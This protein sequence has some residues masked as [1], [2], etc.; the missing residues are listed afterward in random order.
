[1]GQKRPSEER[2]INV[3]NPSERLNEPQVQVII[4]SIQNVDKT[5]AEPKSQS[6]VVSANER[7]YSEVKHNELHSDIIY[8]DGKSQM[9]QANDRGGAYPETKKQAAAN[10]AHCNERLMQEGKKLIL[11][12]NQND[13]FYPEPKKQ[14]ITSAIQSSERA[15]VE[16]KKNVHSNDRHKQGPNTILTND[17]PFQEGKQRILTIDGHLVD[18]KKMF[19][20]IQVERQYHELKQAVPLP[21]YQDLSQTITS[22]D[23]FTEPKKM[24]HG[25]QT[26][27][28]DRSN[29]LDSKAVNYD[30]LNNNNNGKIV[31]NNYDNGKSDCFDS[32]ERKAAFTCNESRR[33][34]NSSIDRSPEDRFMK[35][36]GKESGFHEQPYNDSSGVAGGSVRSDEGYHSHGY[37]DEALTPPE[38]LSDSDDCDNNYVLD[39]RLVVCLKLLNDKNIFQ[40]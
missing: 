13:R 10:Q 37:H 4:T 17:R 18:A 26:I 6:I 38:D 9:I 21:N 33:D 32:S 40:R 34:S 25:Q 1:M 36:E 30:N 23:R 39:Y 22:M 16:I 3:S 19:P 7:H 20:S 15:Y 35:E 29:N 2:L 27:E 14:A 28:S 8:N 12:S 11:S 31:N 5:F 24:I